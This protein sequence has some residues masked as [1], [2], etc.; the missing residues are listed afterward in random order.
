M[1]GATRH[2]L[3]VLL[4]HEVFARVLSLISLQGG[5]IIAEFSWKLRIC[6]LCKTLFQKFMV[7]VLSEQSF[8]SVNLEEVAPRFDLL[9]SLLF[10]ADVR[11]IG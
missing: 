11:F 1:V 4:S 5:G 8:V 9:D 2:G 7:L 3:A 6:G 10:L